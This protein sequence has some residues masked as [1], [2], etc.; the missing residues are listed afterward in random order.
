MNISLLGILA[1]LIL[2]ALP[3]ALM[4]RL[5]I[6]ML[7]NLL[8]AVAK[9]AV[10]MGALGVLLYWVMEVNHLA[11]SLAVVLLMIVLATIESVVGSRQP[12]GRVLIPLL[13]GVGMSVIFFS[14]W[15]LF[16][17]L[18]LKNPFEPQQLI[19]V[20]GFMS[21]AVAMTNGKALSAYYAGLYAHH[22]LY[23]YMTGNGATHN[24]ATS[25]FQRRALERALAPLIKRMAMLMVPLGCTAAWLLIMMNLSPVQ[26]VLFEVLLLITM[27]AASVSSLFIAIWLG[28]YYSFDKYEQLKKKQ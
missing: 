28:R 23:D 18:G 3:I 24:E 11:L 19:P 20:C 8:V 4:V 9:M 27:M 5:R 14:L 7:E 10:G 1:G 17:V 16:L 13:A 22:Q 26:A 25:H 12:R 21:A 6:P 15:F 2:L